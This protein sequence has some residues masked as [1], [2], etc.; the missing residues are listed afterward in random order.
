MQPTLRPGSLLLGSALIKPKLGHIAIIKRRPLSLKRIKKISGEGVWV[1]GD[2]PNASTDSRQFGLI[3][4]K[5]IEAV[6]FMK[7]LV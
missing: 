4:P 1:E 6:I 3:S 7:L 2:N 5:D